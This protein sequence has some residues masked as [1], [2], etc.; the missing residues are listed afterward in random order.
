MD[1]T[2][3]LGDR[4]SAV[5]TREKA[6]GDRQE[7]EKCADHRF[8]A[9]QE[10]S[11]RH[12]LRWTLPELQGVRG[13]TRH[14]TVQETRNSTNEILFYERCSVHFCVPPGCCSDTEADSVF[15]M[16][17][18]KDGLSYR[19]SVVITP[20]A[21]TP[22]N[23]F[24]PTKDKPSAYVPAP[25]RKKRAERNEDNRRSWAN[26]IYTEEDGTLTSDTTLS[27][28][29]NS[30]ASQSALPA[31]PLQWAHEYDSGSESD[32]DRPDPDLVLDDLASRRFHSPSPAPPT[33]FA[34]PIS[35]MAAARAAEGGRGSL[36]KVTMSPTV[37]VQQNATCL[38]SENM[39]LRCDFGLPA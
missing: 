19:R 29:G 8:L 20:K 38:R 18:N 33:N 27:C 31:A 3:Y 26:P 16:A 11:G 35:P 30:Q 9:W 4:Y 24:L 37:T 14:S 10:S 5:Y 39:T 6:P 2:V 23:Q 15:R 7:A 22:F 34:V 12:L 25:L 1:T 17:E 13:I 21:S 28:F 36:P 32:I